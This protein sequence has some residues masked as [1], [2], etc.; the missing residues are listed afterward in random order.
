MSLCFLVV[1]FIQAYESRNS[2]F[3][4]TNLLGTLNVPLG[5]CQ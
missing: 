3:I 2:G 4:S 5:E 1:L